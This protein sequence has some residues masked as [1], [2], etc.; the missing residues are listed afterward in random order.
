MPDD[1]IVAYKLQGN[2]VYFPFKF[3]NLFHLKAFLLLVG[4]AEQLKI[5]VI[6]DMVD[7]SGENADSHL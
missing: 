7:V 3:K 6:N 2:L 1:W 4:I 5:T